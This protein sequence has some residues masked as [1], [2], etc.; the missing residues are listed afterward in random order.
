MS[1]H[2]P[3]PWVARMVDS[4]EWHIDA[5]NGD[6][7]VGHIKWTGLAV[8]GCDDYRQAGSEVSEANARLIAS[9]PELLEAAQQVVARWDTPNWKDARHTGEFINLLRAAIAKATGEQP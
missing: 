1:K 9:A 5:P 3:A 6:P 8:Y 7:T 4:Q 2:T